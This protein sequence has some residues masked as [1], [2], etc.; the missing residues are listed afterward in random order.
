MFFRKKRYE[1]TGK[2]P[3]YIIVGLGNPGRKYEQTR[4][5]VGFMC[6]DLL[7]EQLGVQIKKLKWKSLYAS[8]EIGGVPCLLVK[9]QDFM[10]RSGESVRDICAFYKIPPQNCI[11]VFDDISLP[12]GKIRIRRSGSDGGQKGMNSII[13]LTGTDEYPRVRIGIGA[14]PHPDY[15]LASW[16]LSQFSKNEAEPLR[17]SVINAAEAVKLLVSGD[18]DRAMSM[19]N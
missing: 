6:V 19:Y 3:V 4:H 11:I 12:V 18:I 8:C 2:A 17:E 7:A 15:D 13:Y 9:P 1:K 16:V 10:N 5:N 14:K